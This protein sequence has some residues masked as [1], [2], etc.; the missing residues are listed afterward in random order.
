MV[1]GLRD[2]HLNVSVA[3]LNACIELL[4]PNY[5]GCCNIYRINHIDL[6][7]WLNLLQN[8]AQIGISLVEVPV[9]GNVCVEKFLILSN[10]N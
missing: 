2:Y 4:L 9:L 1:V 3:D 5:N 8:Y 7:G 6:V 10:G